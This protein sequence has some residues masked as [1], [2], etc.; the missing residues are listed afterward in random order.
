MNMNWSSSRSRGREIDGPFDLRP[1]KRSLLAWMRFNEG[2]A[3][4]LSEKWALLEG[5]ENCCECLVKRTI[6]SIRD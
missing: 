5:V 2:E 1:L 4:G 6:G 3:S